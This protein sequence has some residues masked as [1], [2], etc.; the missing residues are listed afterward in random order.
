MLRID[1]QNMTINAVSE[2]EDKV[3]AT[4]NAYHDGIKSLNLNIYAEDIELF[5]ENKEMVNEDFIAFNNEVVEILGSL[6]H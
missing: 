3:I 6:M 4:F 5:I 2:I 1:N